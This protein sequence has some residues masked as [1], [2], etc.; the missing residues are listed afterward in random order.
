M[1][2]LLCRYVYSVHCSCTLC[3]VHC[4]I[5]PVYHAVVSV[6]S[7][8]CSCVGGTG[9]LTQCCCPCSLIHVVVY[10][11]Y[12][13][14]L[15]ALLDTASEHSLQPQQELVPRKPENPTLRIPT[16]YTMLLCKVLDAG[17][18]SSL[19]SLVLRSMLKQRRIL[20]R[21]H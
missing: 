12:K 8:L 20:M 14:T 16:T 10:T 9:V 1:L 6:G 7:V 18:A 11:L 4:A 17:S 15:L 19:P 13:V 21:M 3:H 2:V 5:A